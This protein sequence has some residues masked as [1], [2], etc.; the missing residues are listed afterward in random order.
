MMKLALTP[1]DLARCQG[2]FETNERLRHLPMKLMQEDSLIPVVR[3]LKMNDKP[4][5]LRF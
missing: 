1:K 2:L 4:Q 3:G 5:A